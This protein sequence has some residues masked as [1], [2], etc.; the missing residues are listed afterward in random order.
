MWAQAYWNEFPAVTRILLTS[1]KPRMHPMRLGFF[2]VLHFAVALHVG[3][4]IPFTGDARKD[5]PM[6]DPF[7]RAYED[8]RGDVNVASPVPGT[9]WDISNVFM[10]YDPSVDTAYFGGANTMCPLACC[11][12]F[13]CASHEHPCL[14]PTLRCSARVQASPRA[15]ASLGTLIVTTTPGP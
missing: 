12:C 4:G 13:C 2:L 1:R 9:G 15:I 6:P 10:S 5:F 11:R 8:V 14:V 7:G 3:E